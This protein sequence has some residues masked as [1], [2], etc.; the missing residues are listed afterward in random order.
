M[1]YEGNKT[2]LDCKGY[3]HEFIVYWDVW[4]VEAGLGPYDGR[5]CVHCLENRIGRPLVAKDFFPFPE[6]VNSTSSTVINRI[7]APLLKLYENG[8]TNADE[9]VYLYTHTLVL[10][11][12]S[13]FDWYKEFFGGEIIKESVLLPPGSDQP[14][15]RTLVASI[16]FPYESLSVGRGIYNPDDGRA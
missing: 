1:A 11:R 14:E 12:F 2:C 5:V 3:A 8:T 6:T 13:M 15:Q 7:G 10:Y 4:Q 9:P 16:D